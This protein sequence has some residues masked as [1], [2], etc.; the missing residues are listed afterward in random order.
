M[1][2]ALGAV[3]FNTGV[4]WRG[5]Y[6]TPTVAGSDQST[7]GGRTVVNRLSANDTSLIVLEAIEEDNVRKG[8]FTRPQLVILAGYRDA[9]TNITLNFHGEESLSVVIPT[10]G[11]N[12]EKVLWESENDDT[13]KY[14]G[15][16][17]VKRT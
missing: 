1:T 4:S 12:V 7:L 6:S 8:Y 10:D 14:V 3:T 9:G 5:K 16:I 17:T 15:S 11:I 2:I 13:E